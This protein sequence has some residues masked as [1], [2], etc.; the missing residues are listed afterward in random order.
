MNSRPSGFQQA[1][2][3]LLVAGGITATV[4]C[5]II[6]AGADQ[7]RD[8]VEARPTSTLFQISTLPGLG[9]STATRRPTINA[10]T[11]IVIPTSE[12]VTPPAATPEPTGSSTPT[13]TPTPKS[14]AS[15][16]NAPMTSCVISPSW[17]VYRIQPGDT[18]FSVGLRYGLT[19]DSIMRGNCLTS[20]AIPAGGTLYVPP[21]TPFPISTWQAMQTSSPGD[22]PFPPGTSGV[23]P[24]ATGTQTATDGACTNA[25]SVITS[26]KVG[27]TITGVISI[28]GTARVLN[29]AY[30]KIEVRQEGT[31]VAFANL[32][33]GDHEVTQGTLAT[34][35]TTMFPN[36]EYW[37][38]LVV[39][40]QD[41][42]YPERC[43][44]LVVFLN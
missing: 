30:Y 14:A 35:D 44:K 42:N 40:D 23:P 31:P 38:R 9:G 20:T 32:Y 5:G 21:V 10:P 29:F 3:G 12:P 24:A 26:P 15:P 8:I 39:I 18:L 17:T 2:T 43:S 27:Q 13:V 41:G 25:D 34:L 33:T 19:V 11:V 1:V 6:L 36:G 4:V 22:P 37:L 28:T 7:R 16:T